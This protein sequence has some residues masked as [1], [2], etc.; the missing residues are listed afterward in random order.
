MLKGMVPSPAKW[1]SLLWP[2]LAAV[3]V[4]AWLHVWQ[5]LDPDLVFLAAAPG[6]LHNL[7]WGLGFVGLHAGAGHLLANAGA[8]LVLWPLARQ[9]YPRSTPLA[10]LLAWLIGYLAIWLLGQP[11]SLHMGASALTYGLM[12]QVLVLGVAHRSRPALAAALVVCFLFG[13]AWW[14]LLPGYPG[15]SWEGH[16]GG[17]LGGG[18]GGLLGR[19]WDPDPFPPHEWDEDDPADAVSLLDAPSQARAAQ[20]LTSPRAAPGVWAPDSQDRLH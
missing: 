8:L 14:A 7:P 9:L 12:A 15:V 18:L 17:A 13:A 19:R 1:L 10:L 16:L 2:P 6:T 5:R 20:P 3:I 11:G 4:L